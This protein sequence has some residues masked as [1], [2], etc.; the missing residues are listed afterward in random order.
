MAIYV[1][2]WVHNFEDPLFFFEA[3]KVIALILQN[4]QNGHLCIYLGP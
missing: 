2:I 3:F 1:F 4:T